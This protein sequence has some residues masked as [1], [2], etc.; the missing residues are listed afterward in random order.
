MKTMDGFPPPNCGV[1]PLSGHLFDYLLAS[2]FLIPMPV[3]AEA[4]PALDHH[5]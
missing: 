2:N 1:R 3:P 4:T 5:M